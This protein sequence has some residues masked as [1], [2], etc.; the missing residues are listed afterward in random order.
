MFSQASMRKGSRWFKPTGE[1][2]FTRNISC[3]EPW[4]YVP[5]L[6]RKPPLAHACMRRRAAGYPA[7]LS[8]HCCA[9]L[10]RAENTTNLEFGEWVIR[11]FSLDQWRTRVHS[12]APF[13]RFALQIACRAMDAK[14]TAL[15]WLS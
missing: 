12:S 8:G 11:P 14:M 9:M 10:C 15:R 4:H 2:R 5:L 13:G 6:E 3:F 1:R 7:S